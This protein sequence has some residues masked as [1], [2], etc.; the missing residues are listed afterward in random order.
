METSL[1]RE[2]KE[3]YGGE[4]AQLEVRLGRYR[5]D[6]VVD[7]TLI[8]IQ[9][10]SLSAIRDKI[11]TLLKKHQ[12]L[13]VKPIVARKRLIKLDE[14]GGQVVS[15][16]YSPKRCTLLDVFD[17]LVYFTR[18]FPHPNLKLDVMLVEVEE[19]R[20]PGHGRRRRWRKNDFIVDDQ[21][22]TK[23]GKPH[24]LAT[25]NDLWKLMPKRLPRPFHTGHLA[26]GL[27][28]DRWIAQR[29][30]YCLRKTGTIKQVGKEGNALLY[31]RVKSPVRK[32]KSSKAKTS[33]RKTAKRKKKAA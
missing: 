8:E 13:V 11:R 21:K 1:H 24:R 33:K 18:V 9:H 3:Y 2:L 12:V 20:Y 26:K 5:I 29:I 6:A 23:L 27:E 14:K 22:L 31:E 30:A 25:C 19:T 32:A 17:E 28:I 16:R 10:G 7:E 15:Q 4:D